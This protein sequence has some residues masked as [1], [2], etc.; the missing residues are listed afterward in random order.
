M[1]TTCTHIDTTTY[2]SACQTDYAFFMKFL[3]LVTFGG[4]LLKCFKEY[5]KI[6]MENAF[7]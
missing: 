3:F 1:K 7:D 4:G 2:Y 5:D 6:Q